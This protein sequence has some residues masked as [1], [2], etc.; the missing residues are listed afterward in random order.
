[1][2]SGV[3][4]RAS[5]MDVDQ[6]LIQLKISVCSLLQGIIPL[7]LYV[8]VIQKLLG[9]TLQDSIRCLGIYSQIEVKNFHILKV[10]KHSV[11]CQHSPAKGITQA[12]P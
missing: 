2:F 11:N 1:M 9:S 12:V 6:L 3:L 8:K 5:R 4:N 10:L 7:C